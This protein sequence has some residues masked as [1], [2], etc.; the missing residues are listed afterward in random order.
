MKYIYTIT[1]LDVEARE[2]GLFTD[3]GSTRNSRTWGWFSSL[4][5]AQKHLRSVL[6]TGQ[7]YAVI[8]KFREGPLAMARQEWWYQATYKDCNGQCG[9][10]KLD[11][12]CP[13][14]DAPP[15]LKKI[16]KPKAIARIV[17]F[18]MG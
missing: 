15:T 16:E 9:S 14:C 5:A 12:F 1:L 2:D 18:G 11:A 4:K 8:E 13:G 10:A 17:S 6:W 3:L 7:E